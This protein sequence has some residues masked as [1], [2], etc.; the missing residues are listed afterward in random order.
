[1][2]SVSSETVGIS[3]V[4]FVKVKR[5]WVAKIFTD[6]ET[7]VSWQKVGSLRNVKRIIR[8]QLDPIMVQAIIEIEEPK[9]H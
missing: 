8:N 1:M 3:H 2:A 4:V 6:L 5:Q 9:N 7:C